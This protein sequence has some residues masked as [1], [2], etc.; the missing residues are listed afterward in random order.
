MVVDCKHL[1]KKEKGVQCLSGK[2]NIKT[3]S[4]L[5]INKYNV[6]WPHRLCVHLQADFFRT[7]MSPGNPDPVHWYHL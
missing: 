5:Q 1:K 7:K 2:Q 3:S 6:I 4:I